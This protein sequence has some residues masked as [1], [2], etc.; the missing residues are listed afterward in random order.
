MKDFYICDAAQF[1]NKVVLSS[2][3]VAAKQVKPKRTGDFY[4]SLTLSD[5]TGHLDAK[6]W[7]NVAEI[8]DSFDQDDFVKVKGLINKYNTRFQLTVH[9]LRKLEDSEVDYSD[10]LPKTTKDV[11]QLWRT[12]E[13]F[14]A[15]FQDPYLKALIQ[16][17]MADDQIATAYKIAPAAKNLHHAFIG[18]LLDHVVSLC[19]VC[20]LA[21]RNYPQIDRDLLLT[22]VFLHDIGKIHELCYARSFGYTSRGQLLG[23]MIIELEMLQAK[24]AQ[25]P[26]FPAEMKTLLEHLII[27]HHG[28]YEF[29]SPKL[30]M[31]PEA[32]MLH[33]LDDLDSKMESVRAQ[34]ERDAVNGDGWSGYN[35]SLAR[36]LLDSRRL[37]EKL[38]LAPEVVAEAQEGGAEPLSPSP[39]AELS[40]PIS[41]TA[42]TLERPGEITTDGEPAGVPSQ[43]Q[44]LEL[45][46]RFARP[47]AAESPLSEKAKSGK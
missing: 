7:D 6:V 37:L 43:Q 11:E 39:A 15:S 46:R 41:E 3:V 34:F 29:G 2:F 30:P 12:L 33:Y 25:V 8:M 23:H 9:K 24:V 47:R 16:A 21:A 22:G 17:F 32:L 28:H 26:G 42:E 27:S 1:E 35:P 13:E 44:L 20:D 14:V 10:Y 45:E 4:V 36:P 38:R 5:R 40:L 31:F 18:G 19:T